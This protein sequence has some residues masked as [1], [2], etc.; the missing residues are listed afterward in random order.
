[1]GRS[2]HIFPARK[3]GKKS[4]LFPERKKGKNSP[5]FP[6]GKFSVKYKNPY[7]EKNLNKY[8]YLPENL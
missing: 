7:L 2:P 4:P 5:P 3:K 1:M 6:D 8:K